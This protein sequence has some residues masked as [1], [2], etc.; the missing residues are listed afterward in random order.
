MKPAPACAADDLPSP[1][2]V[3]YTV[4][5]FAELISTGSGTTISE[6]TV[7]A[8]CANEKI[9]GA[10]KVGKRWLIPHSAIARLFESHPLNVLHFPTKR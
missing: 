2:P 10:Y 3:A 5:A 1:A 4:E 7:R 6:R 9:P 8:W